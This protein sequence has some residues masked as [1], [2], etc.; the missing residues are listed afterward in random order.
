MSRRAIT[1]AVLFVLL[2][3]VVAGFVV[4][5]IQ[6]N[7]QYASANQAIEDRQLQILATYRAENPR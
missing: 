7:E 6:F 4:L 3:V 5:R 1:I 2:S